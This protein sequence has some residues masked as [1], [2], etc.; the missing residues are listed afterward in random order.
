MAFG[1]ESPSEDPETGPPQHQDGVRE[2]LRRGR[3]SE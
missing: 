2:Q 3:A 1:L